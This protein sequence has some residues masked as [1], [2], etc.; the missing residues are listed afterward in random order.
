MFSNLSSLIAIN[1][2]SHNSL[3]LCLFILYFM[4]LPE[5]L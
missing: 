1:Y 2:P 5:T 3:L 4:Y